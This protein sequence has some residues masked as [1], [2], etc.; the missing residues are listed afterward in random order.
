VKRISSLL[1][2]LTLTTVTVACA[3]GPVEIRD[4]YYL[5]AVRSDLGG[6]CILMNDLGSATAGYAELAGETANDGSG[7]EPIGTSEDGFT[8]SFDGQ[9][10]ETRDL[11][12][13]R[14]DQDYVGLFAHVSWTRSID[15]VG[16]LE[17]AGMIDADVTG[18]SKVGYSCGI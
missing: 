2:A 16:V 3:P 15:N 14:P 13:S 1:I 9:G 4:W 6:S 12:V 11:F 10:H 5:G 17:N 18:S 8:G 7:W